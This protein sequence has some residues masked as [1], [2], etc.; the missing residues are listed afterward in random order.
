MSTQVLSSATGGKHS[1]DHTTVVANLGAASQNLSHI[2]VRMMVAVPSRCARMLAAGD[3]R[4]SR[5][6]APVK[7]H[8]GCDPECLQGRAARPLHGRSRTRSAKDLLE[9]AKPE[10]WLRSL[11][12]LPRARGEVRRNTNPSRNQRSF[13]GHDGDDARV[14]KSLTDME[15]ACSRRAFQKRGLRKREKAR[16][17]TGFR[18]GGSRDRCPA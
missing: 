2:T 9:F 14:T 3:G 12:L 5:M 8:Q 18:Q 10:K 4:E 15:R 11:S 7:A 16:R 1:F 6:S 17:S 13:W